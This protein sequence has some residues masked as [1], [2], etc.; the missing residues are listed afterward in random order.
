MGDN[1]LSPEGMNEMK[2]IISQWHPRLHNDHRSSSAC[3]AGF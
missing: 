3:D 1:V 2:L